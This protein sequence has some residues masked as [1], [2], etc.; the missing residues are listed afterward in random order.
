MQDQPLQHD[1]MTVLGEVF[2][3]IRDAQDR[4]RVL[5]QG[6]PS[7]P[8]A[9]EAA[10]QATIQSLALSGVENDILRHFGLSRRPEPVTEPEPECWTGEME[11]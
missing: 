1:E 10:R 5:S 7:F 6:S 11:P 8:G 3:I 9:E 2:G 4:L